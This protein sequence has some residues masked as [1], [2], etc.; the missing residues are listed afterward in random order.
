M[1][2]G[3]FWPTYL[4]VSKFQKQFFLKLHCPKNERNIDKILPYEARAEFCQIFRSFFGQWIFKKKCFWDLLT[5]THI[6]ITSVIIFRPHCAWQRKGNLL[7]TFELFN[8]LWLTCSVGMYLQ[9]CTALYYHDFDAG[10]RY[11]SLS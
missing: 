2:F 5:F 9:S 4:K 6:I 10:V 7:L 1:F 8:C 3:H 11:F